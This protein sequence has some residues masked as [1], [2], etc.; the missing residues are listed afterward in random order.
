MNHTEFF[1]ALKQGNIG[2]CY[3]FEGEEEFT[4]KIKV[5]ENMDK[6][7]NP[8]NKIIYRIYDKKTGKIRAD[9]ICLEGE[10]FNPEEDMVIF[11]PN[12]TWKKTRL[13]GGTYTLRELLVPVFKKGICCYTSPSVMDIRELCFKEKNTLWDESLRLVNPQEVYVD[14]SQKLYDTKVKLLE[15][16]GRSKTDNKKKK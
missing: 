1:A 7:T 8:G 2:G 10:T 9:L 3:L 11:D 12:A 4:P 5:S 16:I 15:E 6:V 14:L 13:V